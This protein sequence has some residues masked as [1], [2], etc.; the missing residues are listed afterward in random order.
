MR[1]AGNTSWCGRRWAAK[2]AAIACIL[3][4]ASGAA[5]QGDGRIALERVAIVR[6][7]LVRLADL[8]P[9]DAP[10][11]MRSSAS[12]IVLGD[13]PLPGEE[14]VF[15]RAEIVR[16]LDGAPGLR[17]ELEIPPGV[18]VR[19]WTRRVT[20]EEVLASIERTL[21]ANG[22]AAGAALSAS[23][24]EM[25]TDVAVAEEAP[26]LQVTQIQTS[27][28]GAASRVLVWVTSEPRVPPFWVRVDRPIDLDGSGD[29]RVRD[30]NTASS[31][32]PGVPP[33]AAQEALSGADEIV[34]VSERM[35]GSA[36]R[37][38]SLA[39]ALL[40]KPGDPVELVVQVG[41]MRIQGTGIPLERGREGDEVRV[42]AVPSGKILLG[43]VVGE[44]SVRVSF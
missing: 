8:L 30:A 28:D 20:R 18:E 29:T 11:Q 4:M 17:S 39:G 5:A 34:P 13:A 41:G 36:S 31:V 14:R 2:A 42:R 25:G 24:V 26:A 32:R 40:V 7:E 6:T 12:G 27:S 38:K 10:P 33:S 1:S 22:S 37:E 9:D 35:A 3:L 23:D 44:Q 15:S 19:R 21:R 16:A 43:T